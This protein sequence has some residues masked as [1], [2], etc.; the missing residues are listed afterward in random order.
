ME[1]LSCSDLPRHLHVTS[2]STSLS[3]SD[4]DHRAS[5]PSSSRSRPQISGSS[6]QQPA[7]TSASKSS[8]NQ[9]QFAPMVRGH[10]LE[11]LRPASESTNQYING[12]VPLPREA[13]CFRCGVAGHYI[14]RCTADDSQA[15]QKWETAWLKSMLL[16]LPSHDKTWAPDKVHARSAQVY[17]AHDAIVRSNESRVVDARYAPIEPI[18]QSDSQLGARRAGLCATVEDADDESDYPVVADLKQADRST[19]EAV[20]QG[21]L[22]AMSM[23]SEAAPPSK[24]RK[25]MPLSELLNEDDAVPLVREATAK[26]TARALNEKWGRRCDWQG[27]SSRLGQG[28]LFPRSRLEHERSSW[29]LPPGPGGRHHPR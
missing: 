21:V 3:S 18:P 15:L 7:S 20:A 14:N 24:K 29:R 5:A 27:L 2:S 11:L 10:Q 6:K 8:S 1:R 25:G 12:S 19:M 26:K 9:P 28:P 23:M 16:P 4:S 22:W 17:L 13:V